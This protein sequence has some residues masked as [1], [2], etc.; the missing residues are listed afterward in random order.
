MQ[1]FGLAEKFITVMKIRTGRLILLVLI[2]FSL[3]CNDLL[4]SS[5]LARRPGYGITTG[6]EFDQL[7][8]ETTSKKSKKVTVVA[9]P[10][11]ISTA[12]KAPAPAPRRQI[13]VVQPPAEITAVASST[14]RPPAAGKIAVVPP[15]API[16]ANKSAVK[17]VSSPSVVQAPPLRIN[18]SKKVN[19]PKNQIRGPVLIEPPEPVRTATIP[20]SALPPEILSPVRV[21]PKAIDPGTH[22]PLIPPPRRQ[23][24]PVI[25]SP[26]D[27]VTITANKPAA[28]SPKA[29]G[30]I[31]VS[32]PQPILPRADHSSADSVA[33]PTGRQTLP[34]AVPAKTPGVAPVS[35]KAPASTTDLR[36]L[37]RQQKPVTVSPI[38][39]PNVIP[40]PAEMSA[41]MIS[42][43]KIIDRKPA[44][45]PVVSQ[46]DST[47]LPASTKSVQSSAD[48]VVKSAGEVLPAGEKNTFGVNVNTSSTGRGSAIYGLSSFDSGLHVEATTGLQ[49]LVIEPGKTF[50]IGFRITN[51]SGKA[52]NFTEEFNMP[53]GFEL[54][55]PPAEFRLEPMESYNSIVMVSVPPFLTAGEHQ[56]SYNVF[57]RDNQAVRGDLSFRFQILEVVDL[58]FV[59]EDQPGSVIDGESFIIKGKLVNRSNATLSVD[60]SMEKG[61]GF[62]ANITPPLADLSPGGF[63]DISI[64]GKTGLDSIMNQ[65]INA[66]LVVT[67]RSKKG[68]EILL[69]ENIRLNF[70]SRAESRIDFNNR[71]P[72]TATFNVTSEKNDYR[73]LYELKG[74]GVLDSRGR[75]K[76]DFLVRERTSSSYHGASLNRDEMSLHYSGEIAEVKLGD[77]NFGVSKLSRYYFGRGVG[78]DF[79]SG[80]RT[81]FGALNYKRNWTDIPLNGSGFYVQHVVNDRTFFRFNHLSTTS[82][83]Y[84]QSPDEK[85]STLTF[86]YKSLRGSVLSGEV[87]RKWG[88]E[89]ADRRN[90]AFAVDYSTSFMDMAAFNVSHSDSG[91]I[92]AGGLV[93]NES[94]SSSLNVRISKD[95]SANA[96]YSTTKQN[97]LII[98]SGSNAAKTRNLQTSLDYRYNKSGSFALSYFDGKSNDWISSRYQEK[99]NSIMARIS[100]N[101][102]RLNVNYSIN[103]Q[104]WIDQIIGEERW[105][106]THRL[107]SSY[108]S[109]HNLFISVSAGVSSNSKDSSVMNSGSNNLGLGIDWKVMAN[110]KLQLNC[111]EIYYNDS[112][113]NIRTTGF[114]LA[115]RYF[116]S[117]IDFKVKNHRR[118]SLPQQE[119]MYYELSLSQQFG[120][121]VSRSCKTGALTGVVNEI[122]GSQTVPVANLALLMGNMA[123]I[124]DAKGRFVFADLKPATYSLDLDYRYN[125]KNKISSSDFPVS[126]YIAG[127]RLAVLDVSLEDACSMTG[128]VIVSSNRIPEESIKFEQLSA[129]HLLAPMPTGFRKI[130][131]QNAAGI[132]IELTN[133]DKTHYCMSNN[134][135]AFSAARLK[136]G[137]WSYR[138]LPGSVPEG[139][140]IDKEEG[141]IE[142]VPEQKATLRFTISPIIRTIEMV[143]GD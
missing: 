6:H 82:D 126:I 59:V 124:T 136:R 27:P 93:G 46:K 98:E 120:V 71:L 90:A 119:P 5:F 15:P 21:P 115:Y 55:F 3:V 72:V 111:N 86:A 28:Q 50:S 4:A 92:F 44:E 83:K 113:N 67:D 52:G 47:K 85:F 30:P 38:S 61:P 81:T 17:P 106:T 11:E 73:Y 22:P 33:A 137:T 77:H 76:I 75:R 60:I 1:V 64:E 123:A 118:V 96:F 112:S 66:I 78:I 18:E 133:G 103:R 128:E 134:M 114:N 109:S 37:P 10:R 16:P 122:V 87:A 58:Q 63:I 138:V 62:V 65:A 49:S 140:S 48:D 116:N 121:S 74:K 102:R 9:P 40:A 25:V 68:R 108:R 127:G 143:G 56:F 8:R 13:V 42:Q 43:H 105:L 54:T 39:G 45:A 139:Y 89:L 135:G 94:T 141:Y 24:A 131:P 125:R 100:Q 101:S 99:E 91:V 20:S 35:V 79:G 104:R 95:L 130:T 132:R 69:R 110:L 70:F 19:P 2:S 88:G 84:P 34:A 51:L 12:G 26:P 36:S 14:R 80:K 117:I 29:A 23:P 57:D 129:D 53:P 31:V 142:L 32:A 41:D 97:P 107:N 7:E